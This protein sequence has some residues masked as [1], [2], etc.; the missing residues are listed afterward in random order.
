MFAAKW[1]M[2]DRVRLTFPSNVWSRSWPFLDFWINLWTHRVKFKNLPQQVKR[3]IEFSSIVLTNLRVLN[4]LGNLYSDTQNNYFRGSATAMGLIHPGEN[5]CGSSLKVWND[6]ASD[7][8]LN[9]FYCLSFNVIQ[10]HIKFFNKLCIKPAYSLESGP[11]HFFRLIALKEIGL[12]R[13][14]KACRVS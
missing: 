9:A 2:F 7:Y 4:F 5:F 8:V 14:Y 3:V 13:A 11:F 6:I 12:R 10:T 1:S